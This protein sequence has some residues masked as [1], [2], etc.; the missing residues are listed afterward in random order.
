[1]LRPQ[2]ISITHA[3][4]G[5]AAV[6]KYR[7]D[8]VELSKRSSKGQLRQNPRNRRL[9]PP[10]PGQSVWHWSLLDGKSAGHA[11]LVPSSWRRHGSTR[12]K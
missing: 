7:S 12:A 3:I 10:F 2:L 8:G 11:L 5:R 4:L 9:S 1:M 6:V